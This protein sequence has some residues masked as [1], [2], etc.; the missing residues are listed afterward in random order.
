E[1]WKQIRDTSKTKNAPIRAPNPPSVPQ[2][3]PILPP[4]RISPQPVIPPK[5][6]PSQAPAADA[7]AQQPQ[8]Q[9][10]SPVEIPKVVQSV[11]QQS[12]KEMVTYTQHEFY[13]IVP[14][15]RKHIKEQI[16]THQIPTP[17][18]TASSSLYNIPPHDDNA[19]STTQELND[20]V[21]LSVLQQ[22]HP[23]TPATLPITVSHHPESISIT[24]QSCFPILPLAF[25]SSPV[26]SLHGPQEIYEIRP[27]TPTPIST[28]L[29]DNPRIMCRISR[30][31]LPL[32]LQ[33]LP[34]PPD[35]SLGKRHTRKQKGGRKINVKWIYLMKLAHHLARPP[36]L[37]FAWTN[38][39][40]MPLANQHH[41]PTPN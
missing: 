36:E 21:P 33:L 15:I 3:I 16:N 23:I 29:P 26:S 35:S 14:D 18:T 4:T 37:R 20:E 40:K 27:N 32:M 6:P 13:A 19:T 41:T 9:L 12:L 1:L 39:E 11:V 7:V 10:P 25:T 8:Y 31:P 2:T 22:S 28:I 30:N 24:H 34:R 5:N 38:E 17:P